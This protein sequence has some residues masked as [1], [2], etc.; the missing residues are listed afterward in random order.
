MFCII[1]SII[2]YMLSTELFTSMNSDSVR[3]SL[4]DLC[5]IVLSILDEGKGTV[6]SRCC[7]WC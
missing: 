2:W 5:V 4:I 1:V 6:G 3:L 7:T